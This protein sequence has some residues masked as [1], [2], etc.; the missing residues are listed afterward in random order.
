MQQHNQSTRVTTDISPSYELL[1]NT[2]TFTI[3]SY[4]Y[5]KSLEPFNG[6]N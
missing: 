5:S 2:L 3:L 1:L 4:G 6:G